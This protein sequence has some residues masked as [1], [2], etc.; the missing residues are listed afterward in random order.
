MQDYI[1]RIE[2]ALQQNKECGN[3]L[4][5]LLE[6]AKKQLPPHEK[7]LSDHELRIEKFRKRDLK[8]YRH[9]RNQKTN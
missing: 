8:K 7:Y 2:I 5:L 3:S 6:E 9:D 1:R 4:E